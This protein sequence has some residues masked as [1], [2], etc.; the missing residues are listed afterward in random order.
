MIKNA[1]NPRAIN[2]LGVNLDVAREIRSATIII[3]RFWSCSSKQMEAE[4]RSSTSLL[5]IYKH[6]RVLLLITLSRRRWPRERDRESEKKKHACNIAWNGQFRERGVPNRS[7]I[8]ISITIEC[9]LCMQIARCCE[10]VDVCVA[11]PSILTVGVWY[12]LSG[13][14]FQNRERLWLFLFQM[15][16]SRLLLRWTKLFLVLLSRSADPP[17]PFGIIFNP[18]FPFCLPFPISRVI[19]ELG[20]LDSRCEIANSDQEQS[21]VSQRFFFPIECGANRMQIGF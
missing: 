14:N 7:N 17:N 1:E 12:Q 5:N 15:F 20:L 9:V 6:A 2:H 19:I 16:Q 11:I 21:K 13:T 3:I 8:A 4:R 18:R 10:K